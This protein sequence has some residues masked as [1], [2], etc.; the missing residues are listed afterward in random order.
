MSERYV[1]L[2]DGNGNVIGQYLEVDPPA[3][4]EPLPNRTRLTRLEFRNMMTLAE[5]QAFYT[6]AQTDINA[7]IL[8]DDLATAEYV[9]LTDQSTIDA[10][11]YLAMIGVIAPAR[12]AEILAGIPQ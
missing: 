10:V 8:K 6:A 9:E 11:G 5:K 2:L 7:E 3:N 1:D 4:L 12:V